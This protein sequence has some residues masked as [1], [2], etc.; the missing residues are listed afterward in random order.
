MVEQLRGAHRLQGGAGVSE[1]TPPGPGKGS[2]PL[3]STTGNVIPTTIKRLASSQAS[4]L[5]LSPG[6]FPNS[7]PLHQVP[8]GNNV[9][10]EFDAEYCLEAFAKSVALPNVL[11]NLSPVDLQ[12]FI[13]SQAENP[14]ASAELNN[15]FVHPDRQYAISIT[16][17]PLSISFSGPPQRVTVRYR[18]RVELL[19]EFRRLN[20]GQPEDQQGPLSAATEEPEDAGGGAAL[21]TETVRR[22]SQSSTL[23][24]GSSAQSSLS[25]PLLL[26]IVLIGELRLV[27]SSNYTGI[28]D[29]DLVRLEIVADMKTADTQVE[30]DSTDVERFYEGLL[31]NYE[32]IWNQRATLLSIV[33]LT[34]TISLVGS[35]PANARVDE[36]PDFNFNVFHVSSGQR[37]ALTAAFSLRAGQQVQAGTVQHFIGNQQYG[38]ISD[39]YLAERLLKYRFRLNGLPRELAFDQPVRITRDGQEEDARVFGVIRLLTLDSVSVET[40]SNLRTDLIVLG[41]TGTIVPQFLR[42]NDGTNVGPD[43][44]DLGGDQDSPWRVATGIAVNAS[45]SGDPQTRAFQT[46]VRQDGYRHLGRP[47]ANEAISSRS[48]VLYARTE[49]VTKQLFFLG[50]LPPL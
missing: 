25:R 28:P 44:V 32:H 24:I 39:E 38:M 41:G 23:T 4:T 6:Y 26:P 5:S 2:P 8:A 17:T 18:G 46:R 12:N 49:G 37:Q 22:A 14:F 40:D 13:D 29:P 30:T 21:T 3:G 9:V 35:N 45:L 36:L 47:F 33:P 19:E 34:P 20:E 1:V 10:I 43:Q 15:L 27:I 48:T 42:L 31:S 7:V 16:F 50:A 11:V